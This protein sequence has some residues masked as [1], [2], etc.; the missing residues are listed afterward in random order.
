MDVTV[1]TEKQKYMYSVFLD[2]VKDPSLKAIIVSSTNATVPTCWEKMVRTVEQSVSA[3]LTAST[4]LTYITSIKFDDGK[5]R[6]TSKDFIIHWCEQVWLLES[7]T[8]PED[9]FGNTV[10][11]HLLQNTIDGIPDFWQV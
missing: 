8:K 1:F 5:W 7:L 3:E 2:K 10:K 4:I 11:T 9:H 6:G